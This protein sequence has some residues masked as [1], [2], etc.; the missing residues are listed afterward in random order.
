[1]I[2]PARLDRHDGSSLMS[3]LCVHDLVQLQASAKP[4]SVALVSGN[5]HVTYGELNARANQ[6]AH[7]LRSLGIGPD[8]PVGLCMERSVELPIA[9]LGI[10]KAGGA[11]VPL[12]PSYPARR[13]SMLLEDSGTPL[14]VAQP[15]VA[16]KLPAG[17]WETVF[18]DRDG[19]D[20]GFGFDS[21][22]TPVANTK[23]ENLAYIIF[24]SG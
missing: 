23:P 19:L 1:M 24:T 22:A 14:V 4:D 13:L 8:V 10:L 18:L 2:A 6:L 15:C 3:N 9:A 21:S 20:I 11:Y 12:D 7:R 17:K 16:G 5:R